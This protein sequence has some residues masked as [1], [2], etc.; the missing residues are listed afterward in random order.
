MAISL[1]SIKRGGSDR[2]PI[3][4]VHGPPGMGKT[5]FAA[6]AN[7]VV[8]IRTEDG[9][10]N[11]DVATFPE[12]GSLAEVME[13]LGALYDEHNYQAV[14]IDSLSALEPLV[15]KQVAEDQGKK[16]I[17]SIGYAKGYIY[18]LDYWRE[19]VEACKGL[20]RK[21]IMP[22]LI[23]HTDIVKFE[24]PEVE[25]Y[26]RYQIKLHKKAFQ[27]LYEQADIIGFA[28]YPVH[29]KKND[30]DDKKG[31]GVQKGERVL[32][33]VETPAYV[34]KNRYSL[35]EKLPLSWA[36]FADALGAAMK[37]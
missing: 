37:K 30:A 10:G 23:A 6:G 2:A 27:Y 7:D 24:S 3:V 28:N 17:E 13:A 15:W 11:L 5:T 22:I 36:A 1:D 25:P 31:R 8:F 21:G 34:A 35:P 12:C 14:A 33:F 18:A 29:V 4:V 19:I 16:N 20:A 32:H 26:D 9:L